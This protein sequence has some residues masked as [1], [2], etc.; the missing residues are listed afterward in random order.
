MYAHC[1]RSCRPYFSFP[2]E[3]LDYFYCLWQSAEFEVSFS[4]ED[5]EP[6]RGCKRRKSSTAAK[7][8]M[9]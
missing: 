2:L 7:S 3:V 6:R 5:N 4:Q 8:I 1:I 9:V